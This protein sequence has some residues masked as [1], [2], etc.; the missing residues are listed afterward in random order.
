M[1]ALAVDRDT[2]PIADPRTPTEGNPMIKLSQPAATSARIYVKALLEACEKLN[3]TPNDLLT[4]TAAVP[5]VESIDEIEFLVGWFHGVAEQC[6]VKVVVLWRELAPAPA[7]PKARP[8]VPSRKPRTVKRTVH[9][10]S[11]RVAKAVRAATPEA[12]VIV[13]TRPVV[14]PPMPTR[15]RR[16]RKA[17]VAQG[18]LFGGGS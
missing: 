2:T 12:T 13:H 5:K 9:V 14:I 18:A 8:R 17:A 1:M 16:T 6:G 4:E 10:N 3:T 11:A 7:P 15:A